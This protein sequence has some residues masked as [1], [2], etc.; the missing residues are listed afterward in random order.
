MLA[1]RAVFGHVDIDMLA[2]PSEVLVVADAA[3]RPDFIAAD[4]LAQ[5]EHDALASC[6]LVTD[7][8]RIAFAVASELSR[9]LETLPRREIARAAL[10]DWGLIARTRSLGASLELANELAPEHLELL[11]KNPRAAAAKLTTAGAI[12]LGPHATEPLGDYVAGPSHTLPTGG[13]A[14]AFSG[15]SVYSFLRRTS[16]IESN[17][18]G[19]S[20]VAEAIA[21]LA[22][23]EGLEAHK[24]AVLIRTGTK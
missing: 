19:L 16:L 5:A 24:R 2:G 11:V 9:Q 7:S 22:D 21:T 13:T 10:R 23:A 12:F 17:A 8:A 14:S 4:L 15:L 6:V 18:A 3:A 1:K 20:E